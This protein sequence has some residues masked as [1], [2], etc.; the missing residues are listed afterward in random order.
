ME[1]IKIKLLFTSLLLTAVFVVKPSCA[2][3]TENG[4]NIL[5]SAK[6]FV[7]IN[8]QG[9]PLPT[10][11]TPITVYT[12]G[13]SAFRTQNYLYNWYLDNRLQTAA[14][15]QGKNVFKYVITDA[16][17]SVHTVKAEIRR[18]NSIV[19]VLETKIP[20]VKSKSV[21]LA[22]NL[23]TTNKTISAS[24]GQTIDIQAA[25][26]YFNITGPSDAEYAWTINNASASSEENEQTPNILKLKIPSAKIEYDITSKLNLRVTSKL[27][28]LEIALASI[29]ITIKTFR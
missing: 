15:G 21:I 17:G 20:I 10:K 4:F 27:N 16:V 22:D 3:A 7:P 18:A 24:A 6:S 1:Q 9:K 14:S 23:D 25:P 5:W 26:Y 19:A 11:G 28:A 2:L 13:K 8:Y 29:N 12:Q